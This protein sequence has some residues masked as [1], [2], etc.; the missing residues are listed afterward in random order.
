MATAQLRL[1]SCG[2]RE[3]FRGVIQQKYIST[4]LPFLIIA[5]LDNSLSLSASSSFLDIAWCDNELTIL[6]VHNIVCSLVHVD[7]IARDTTCKAITGTTKSFGTDCSGHRWGPRFASTACC[8]FLE[9][10][11]FRC[12]AEGNNMDVVN[13]S[14]TRS[15]PLA[16]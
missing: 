9:Y 16:V 4:R 6:A 7:Q 11:T 8:I 10:V 1:P 15:R 13:G 2:D 3:L 12:P 14:V 5:P